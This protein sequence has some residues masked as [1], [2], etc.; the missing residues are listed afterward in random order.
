ML[1][2]SRLSFY[3]ATVA[4]VL[5]LWPDL[6][7]FVFLNFISHMFSKLE[8]VLFCLNS[9]SLVDVTWQSVSQQ[10]AVSVV[11]LTRDGA[12]DSNWLVC[13]FGSIQR[14]SM[15]TLTNCGFR[16]SASLIIYHL[17]PQL[18]NW[19]SDFCLASHHRKL[20]F[21]SPSVPEFVL[22]Q[23]LENRIDDKHGS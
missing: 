14:I 8:E 21:Y 4:F 6:F 10:R 15:A 13:S 7:F 2:S 20:T 16:H 12:R 22:C 9:A 3:G 11:T 23:R 1:C 18:G 19:L 5:S 17:L